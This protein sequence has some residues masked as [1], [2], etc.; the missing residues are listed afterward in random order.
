M[1]PNRTDNKKVLSK[2]IS[3]TQLPGLQLIK[4][5][6]NIAAGS[7]QGWNKNS[8]ICFSIL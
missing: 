5:S 1:D 7:R 6:K 2:M 8:S 4:R 3:G